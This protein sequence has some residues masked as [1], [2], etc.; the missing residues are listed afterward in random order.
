LCLDFGNVSEVGTTSVITSGFGFCGG[1]PCPV[2]P[3]CA[4]PITDNVLTAG[5]NFKRL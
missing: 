1:H 5:I 3:A 2:T 4:S